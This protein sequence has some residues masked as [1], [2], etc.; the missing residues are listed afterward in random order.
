[1]SD[2]RADIF[3]QQGLE[4]LDA[5]DLG[6]AIREF[7]SAIEFNS[8]H[9]EA[10]QQLGWAT[11]GSGGSLE[12][13]RTY[14][15]EAIEI[16]SSLGD[17]HMYLGIVQNRLKNFDSSEAHFRMALSLTDDPALAH[18]TF[19]EEF[20]WHN[21]RYGEAEEH[22]RAALMHDPDCVLAI[23]NYARMLGCHGRDAE[24]KKHFVAA[25]ELD[26]CNKYTKRTFDEFLQDIKCEDRDPDDCLRAAI[27]K[28]PKY[29][30]GIISLSKRY[31]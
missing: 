5:R 26:P 31:R 2:S 8:R 30:E 10:Y 18:A 20:L 12:E 6:R 11:Y 17:T 25:L 29:T 16:D 28:D 1:M 21:S 24:A 22:F 15:E 27:N 19:A 3:Y 7:R 9:A 4:A 23:R 13:A 14:L